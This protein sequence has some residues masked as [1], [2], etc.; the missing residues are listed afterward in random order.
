[1]KKLG[2]FLLIFAVH[3]IQSIIVENTSVFSVTPNIMITVII[4]ISVYNSSVTSVVAGGFAGLLYDSLCGTHFGVYILIYM[5]LALAVS[6]TVDKKNGNSPLLM[7]WTGF[8]YTVLLRIVISIGLWIIGLAKSFVEMGADALVKGFVSAIVIFV[9]VLL[10]E[11]VFS[12]K[13]SLPEGCDI[14]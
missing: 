5:Y 8:V 4:L 13:K 12:A 9:I 3:L 2:I 14:A 11:Y 1:M 6:Y 10:K 7:A